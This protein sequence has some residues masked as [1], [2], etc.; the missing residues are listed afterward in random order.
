MRNAKITG[1]GK[2]LP[3][4]VLSNHDIESLI[5]TNDDWITTR[6]GIKERRISHVETSDMAAI[7]GTRAIAA[8]GLV[9]DDIDLIILATCSADTVIPAAAAMVQA[10]IGAANAAAFDL[11]AACS[12][13]LYGLVVADNMI[14]GGTNHKVLV[15]GSEKLHYFLDFTDRSTAVLFGDGAGAVILEAT[16]EDCGLRS[17]ELGMDGDAAD[18]LCIPGLGTTGKVEAPDPRYA[19]VRMEGSEVFRRAVTMMGDASERVIAKAGLSLDDV[20]LLVPHQANVRIIDATARRVKLDPEKVF[21]NIHAYGNTSAAT[22]PIALT[23]ALEAGRIKPGDNI[24]FAAFGGGLTWGAAVFTWG[25]RV[26][27]I[28]VSDVDFPPSSASALELLQSN[29]EFFGVGEHAE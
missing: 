15:V 17:S 9:A 1:W 18:L 14:K 20:D 19:G 4:A 7:A 8:A 5:D 10:K 26:E 6:T 27:P 2:A 25:D 13:F 24:L 11:N 28:R 16:D 22:I 29:F 23:E 12:G 3:K 21:V